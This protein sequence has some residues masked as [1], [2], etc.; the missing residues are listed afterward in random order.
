M[1]REA[2]P[3]YIIIGGKTQTTLRN[4]RRRIDSQ[5]AAQIAVDAATWPEGNERSSLSVRGDQSLTPWT[6]SASGRSRPVSVL[7]ADTISERHHERGEQREPAAAY[8]RGGP[9]AE[10]A[11]RTPSTAASVGTTRGAIRS[12]QSQNPSDADCGSTLHMPEDRRVERQHGQ[13]QGSADRGSDQEPRV[14]RASRARAPRHPPSRNSRAP[15]CVI[16]LDSSP[17]SGPFVHEGSP[18]L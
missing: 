2:Q 18:R 1:D 15:W 17:S 8:A 7:T 5:S 13:R 12:I 6:G 16:S 3:A 14:I 4:G 10:G 11:G 9:S